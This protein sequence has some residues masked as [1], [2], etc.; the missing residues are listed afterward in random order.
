MSR[1]CGKIPNLAQASARGSQPSNP[2]KQAADN[3]EAK[4][5][6]ASPKVS[7]LRHNKQENM[8]PLPRPGSPALLP[9]WRRRELRAPAVGQRK[10]GRV[11]ATWRRPEAEPPSA[12]WPIAAAGGRSAAAA[13][14]AAKPR[15]QGQTFVLRAMEAVRAAVHP[16]PGR[17]GPQCLKSTFHP[18]SPRT[19]C[20][21][22]LL[23]NME[24]V[25]RWISTGKENRNSAVQFNNLRCVLFIAGDLC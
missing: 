7:Y 17:P 13:E 25:F 16:T 15:Q 2:A 19:L 18:A 9:G 20:G 10:R 23:S 22:C 1:A 5:H 8:A 12:L 4:R 21:R 24:T 11:C 6:S 14:T 3:S